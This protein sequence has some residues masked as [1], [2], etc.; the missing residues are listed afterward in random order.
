MQ[1]MCP[2]KHRMCPLSIGL[3]ILR[4]CGNCGRLKSHCTGNILLL[5]RDKSVPE[6]SH[7]DHSRSP[8]HVHIPRVYNAAYDLIQRNLRA[9]LADKVAYV[10]DRRSL[11]FRELDARSSAFA[12]TLGRLG[13]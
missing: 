11:T 4:L 9:D 1:K 3:S 13:V 5:R 10:D 12:N 6:P 8:P 2:P 7:V